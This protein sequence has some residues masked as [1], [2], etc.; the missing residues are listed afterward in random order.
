MNLLYLKLK[1]QFL[2]PDIVSDVPSFEVLVP[3][4]CTDEQSQFP[5]LTSHPCCVRQILELYSF[6]VMTEPPTSEC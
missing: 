1:G 5:A 4:L 6:Y 2:L 3:F